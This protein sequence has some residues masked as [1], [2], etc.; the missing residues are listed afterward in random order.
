M[1]RWRACPLASAPSYCRNS[2][3]VTSSSWTTCEPTTTH[4]SRPLAQLMGS[5][6][7]TCRR[8]RQTSTRSSQAGRFRSSTYVASPLVVPTRCAE[9][10]VVHDIVSRSGIVRIGSLTAATQVNPTDLWVSCSKICRR[11]HPT[12]KCRTCIPCW[13]NV[14]TYSDLWRH[15]GN[16][17]P[18]HLCCSR[19]SYKAS[20][21]PILN[22][23]RGHECHRH[24]RP[25]RPG[26]SIPVQNDIRASRFHRSHNRQQWLRQEGN[27]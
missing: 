24:T 9:W 13:G 5:A 20:A 21:C 15:P 3:V 12:T 23:T 10:H 27:G 22:R 8:T 4:A 1:P 26:R 2:G 17:V 25:P 14:N 6:S 11:H 19:R 18:G 7:S 16:N